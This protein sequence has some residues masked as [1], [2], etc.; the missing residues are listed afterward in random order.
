MVL[1]MYRRPTFKRKDAI[2]ANANSFPPIL[3]Y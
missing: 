3:N 1:F 2:K